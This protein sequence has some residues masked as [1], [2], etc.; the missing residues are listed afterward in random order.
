MYAI[1][2]DLVVAET[3]KHHPKG[4]PSVACSGQTLLPL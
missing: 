1:A 3:K 2:F 4:D